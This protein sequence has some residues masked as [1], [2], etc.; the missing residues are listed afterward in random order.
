MWS[1]VD[2]DISQLTTDMNKVYTFNCTITNVYNNSY[3]Y[4]TV[5]HAEISRLSNRSSTTISSNIAQ[6][7]SENYFQTKYV[8]SELE[9]YQAMLLAGLNIKWRNRYFEINF[10]NVYRVSDI[11]NFVQAALIARQLRT[12]K[13]KGAIILTVS[14]LNMNPPI[15]ST[16]ALF[17]G[18]IRLYTSN[19]IRP[20]FNWLLCN[21]SAVS[22]IQYNRLFAA[23]GTA[24]GSGD[25]HTTFNLPDLRG[26][27][28]LGRD[29]N[30][31]RSDHSTK[32]GETGGQSMHTLTVNHLPS[33]CHDFGNLTVAAA[34]SHSHTI[35]DPGHSHTTSIREDGAGSENG[36]YFKASNGRHKFYSDRVRIQSQQT[37]VYANSVGHHTHPLTGATAT[38]G[39]GQQYSILNPFQTFDYYI[40]AGF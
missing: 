4:Y 11:E 36:Y 32:L 20:P 21:G 7:V 6:F 8:V 39:T 40:Y 29:Q 33:H 19:T 37:G 15:T 22:R 38:T 26:R 27:V 17:T 34:G 9:I 35:Y 2:I 30:K 3:N 5:N 24:Y 31:S 18:E 25:N 28:P 10:L 13:P 12:E 1:S 14:A 16:P 23:I